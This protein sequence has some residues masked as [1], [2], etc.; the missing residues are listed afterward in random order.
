MTGADSTPAR[1]EGLPLGRIAGIP[2][3]LAWSWFLITAVIVM[4]A[5][6]RLAG[7]LPGLGAAAYAVG[8][9]YALLLA[10]S[11]LVHELAH[12]LSARAAGWPASRIVLTL[13]GG[14]TQFGAFSP[15]P[16]R[17]LAVALAGPAANFLLALAGW[18]LTDALRPYPVAWLLADMFVWVNVV[19]GVFNVL[20]GLPLDGGRIVESAVWKATGNQHRGTVAAGWGGRLIAVAMVAAVFGL[21]MLNGASPDWVTII[22]AFAVGA[23][24]WSGATAAIRSAQ[25]RMRLPDISAGRLQQPAVVVPV[26]TTADQARHL[27]AIRPG[28]ALL[29]AGSGGRAES[30]VDGAALSAIPDERAGDTPAAAAARALPTGA[31]VRED[32]EGSELLQLLARLPGNEYPVVDSRGQVTGLLAQTA[33]T[34]AITGRRRPPAP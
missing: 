29:L 24:L 12:G 14:H 11:V 4:L 34:A 32:A 19:V 15:G 13:W 3:Y 25:L 16:G 10:L 2:V 8:L 27:L 31:W 17:S 28:T 23:F 26:G 20:P 9:G 22:I 7:Q 18:L 30:V 6:P 5:G 21:P 33:V 1:R